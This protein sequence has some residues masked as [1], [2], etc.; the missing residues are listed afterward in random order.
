MA[1]TERELRIAPFGPARGIGL[2]MVAKAGEGDFAGLWQK[3]LFPRAGEIRRPPRAAAFGVCRCIP[4]ATD[5]SFEY[6]ALLEATA[7]SPVPDGMMALD[8]PAASY[9][10]FRAPSLGE[11]GQTW[12]SVP[13]AMAAQ[14]AWKPYCGADGCRCA[15]HPSFEYHAWDCRQT[16]KVLIYVPV[17]RAWAR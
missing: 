3:Q 10:V 7:D 16:G 14:T 8:I 11:L 2:A 1:E 12:A 4:G 6:L 17:Y 5:G 13:Q 15:T 9:A